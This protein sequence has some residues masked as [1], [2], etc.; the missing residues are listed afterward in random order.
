[1]EV[2]SPLGEGLAATDM[3]TVSTM[4]VGDL[5]FTDQQMAILDL[6]GR[7]PGMP[8]GV[9]SYRVFAGHWLELDMSRQ[10]VRLYAGRLPPPND[11]DIF[12]FDGDIPSVPVTLGGHAFDL[13]LD[14]GSPSTFT[15]PLSAAAQL[16]LQSAPTVVGRGRT[17]DAD[18]EILGATLYG[19]AVIGDLTIERPEVQFIDGAAVGHVGSRILRRLTVGIDPSNRR[20]RLATAPAP[21]DDSQVRRVALFGGDRKRYGIRFHDIDGE[22]LTVAGVDD[23]APAAAGDR[24]IELNGQPVASLDRKQ[25]VAA[26]QRSPLSLTIQRGDATRRIDMS[27][28]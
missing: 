23:G 4:A 13:H 5:L 3:V 6:A 15:L 10:V 22:P 27:L 19:D 7:M 12:D 24:I 26:L 20:V 11:T 1:M 9:L 21:G 14:T 17:V 16:P 18:F 28:D 25:R 2:S 8:L